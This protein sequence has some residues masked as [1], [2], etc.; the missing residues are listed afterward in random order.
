[1]AFNKDP[2]IAKV[3]EIAV[4][5]LKTPFTL[6]EMRRQLAW[7]FGV[8]VTYSSVQEALRQLKKAGLLERV[9][10]RAS[11]GVWFCTVH[12][13]LAHAEKIELALSQATKK[14][15]VTHWKLWETIKRWWPD[16]GVPAPS[17][18]LAHVER[19]EKEGKAEKI[20]GRWVP[21]PVPD[22]SR[23]PDDKLT[24][25][26]PPGEREGWESLW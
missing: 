14:N 26:L 16:Q 22:R 18:I 23:P 7:H 19:L 8:R 21:I 17:D 20:K 11:T 5:R 25:D 10:G 15:P 24:G 6:D 4:M 9:K 3:R 2:V 12:R 13:R 1:M